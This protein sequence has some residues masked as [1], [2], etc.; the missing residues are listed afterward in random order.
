MIQNNSVYG[1]LN[2]IPHWYALHTRY[3][4]ETK[5][6][7]LLREKNIINY[8]PLSIEFHKWSDRY[9]KVQLPLF[10]CYVFVFIALR[11]R[12][13]VLQTDGAI[14][15]LSFNGTPAVIP[16]HQIDAIKRI[17]AEKVN[18]DRTDFFTSGKKVRVKHGP[19]KGVEGTL[20]RKKN[21]NRLV[22][23]IDG[24]KQVLSIEID[25]R[26]LEIL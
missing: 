25:Y 3:R 5:V 18:V 14:K 10:S 19:L 9:K 20:N 2:Y 16:D 15:L 24:I 13:K 17:M 21:Q 1:D 6:H 7:N 23:A 22:I 26:D 11:D 12:F 4:Y 8:L